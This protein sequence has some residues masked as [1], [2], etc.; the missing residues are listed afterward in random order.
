MTE[1][2]KTRYIHVRE[3]TED[4]ELSH[5][6]GRTIA[7]RQN[8]DKNSIEYGVAFVNPKDRYTKKIGRTFADKYLQESPISIGF[9]VFKS[10]LYPVICEKGLQKLTIRDLGSQLHHSVILEH[11]EK[12]ENFPISGMSDVTAMANELADTLHQL[13]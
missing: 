1:V 7:W 9:D 5:K 6:G 2:T 13:P 11:L 8:L 4:D 3:Y 12:M 10:V